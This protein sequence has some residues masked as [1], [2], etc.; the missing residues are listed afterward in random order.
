M[1]GSRW[2]RG[3]FFGSVFA[4]A[5]VVLSGGAARPTDLTAPSAPRH[6]PIV[7]HHVREGLVTAYNWSG[8]GVTGPVGSVTDVKGSW[9][10][11]VV[12]CARGETSYSSFWV[13]IDGFTSSTVEQTGTDSDCRNGVP[14]YSAWFEFYP[15]PMLIVN[16][17]TISPGDVMSA[18]VVY[19][20]SARRF[21]VTLVDKTTGQS[22]STSTKV[23]GAQRSSAEWIAE[24]PSSASGILPLADFGT[25][26][27]GVDP[28]VA[29][30]DTATVGGAPGPIGS[31]PAATVWEITMV[32]PSGAVKAQPSGLGSDGS[33]FSDTWQSSGP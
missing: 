21:T 33:S 20:P 28:G 23:S 30:P 6:R 4:L 16:S 17:L 22:F 5:A 13:G 14:T 7:I 11:P 25:V 26:D 18:E 8:Y 2:R 19:S 12:T 32:S 15:H 31:F 10:V 1:M 29:N 24:A 27:F 3:G 9:T